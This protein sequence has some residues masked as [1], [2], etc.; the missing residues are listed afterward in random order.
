MTDGPGNL[1]TRTVAEILAEA[2]PERVDFVS[3]DVEGLEADILA[4]FPFDRYAP[5][6]FCVEILDTTLDGVIASPVTK[7]FGSHGYSI[8]GWFPPSVFFAR[9][10]LGLGRD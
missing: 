7:T 8:V 4:A 2:A 3:I 1:A 5:E 6:L 9:R 10:P